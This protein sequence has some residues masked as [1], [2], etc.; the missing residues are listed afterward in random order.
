MNKLILACLFGL[1]LVS[2]NAQDKELN[3]KIN[4]LKKEGKLNGDEAYF[5][6]LGGTQGLQL[7]TPTASS[8][9]GSHNNGTMTS[10]ACNCWIPRDTS[11]HVVPF[12]GSGGSGGPGV[13]PTYANDDWSTNGITLPFNFCLYGAN[14]GSGTKKLFINNNGNVSFGSAYSTFSAVAFPSTQYIMV[15]PFWGDVETTNAGSGFVYYKL[16]PT[17]LIV[18]WDS[19]TYYQSSSG[20]SQ[21]KNTFQLIITDG[22]DP[23]LSSGNNVS[24]CYGD[25]QWTTGDASGGTN[26]FGGTPATVGINKGS[27]GNYVQISLFGANNGNFTNPAG[28]PVSGVN[29]LDNKSFYFNSCGSSTNLPPLATSGASSCAGDTINICAVG[30]TVIQSVSFTGPEPSQIVTVTASAPGIGSGFSILNSTAGT[31]GSLTFQVATGSLTTGYYNVS[32]TGTDNGI[33]VQSTTL[34]YVIHILG[35]AVPSP[36]ITVNP[37]ITCGNTPAIFTLTN[38]SSYDSYT[39]SNGAT[40]FS[41]SVSIT[42]T[43]QVTVVKNGCS[44][45]GTA[46]AY[47][48]PKPLATIGGALS[49]CSPAT[50]TNIY[51]NQP[52]TGGTAPFTYN[53]D[54][55]ASSS[56]SLTASAGTH[57]VSVTDAHGC[58]DTVF[59]TV[60]GNQVPPLTIIAKGSLCAGNDTLI[61]S[62]TNA[63]SYVWTPAGSTTYT[64]VVNSPGIYSLNVI[65]N[66]CPTSATYSLSP[67]I[68]PTLTVTGEF[69][70][71][72][73]TSTT[74]TVTAVPTGTYNYIW[75]GGSNVTGNTDTINMANTYTV[76]GVNNNTQCVG[77]KVFTVGSYTNPI[78]SISGSTTY[79]KSKSD[80][81][82]ANASGGHGPYTYSWSPSATV[83]QVQDS[84]GIVTPPSNVTNITY[85]VMIID[86]KGCVASAQ[87]PLKQSNPHLFVANSGACAGKTIVLNANGSGTAPLTYTWTNPSGVLPTIVIGKKDSAKAPG[88]YTVTMTD[89][90]GCTA[91]DSTITISQY[92]TPNANFTYAPTAVEAGVPATF[93]DASTVTTG[94]ITSDLWTF[95]DMDSA[96]VSNPIHTYN[97]GGTYT[98]TLTVKSD[99]GCTNMITKFIDIQYVVIAPNIITPNGDG[100]NEFLAFKNLQYFKNN[101]L[102]IYNRWGVQLYTDNDY[103]NNWT[104]KDFSDGTYFYI[105]DLP[106]KHT[107]LKGFFESI[108]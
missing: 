11:F 92:P 93:T 3:E 12:D 90:Y 87:V 66:N 51:V 68:T 84:I 74:L 21:L 64:N 81:L 100:I 10:T 9:R 77:T 72:S 79:C 57:T 36:S 47:I 101:K 83:M 56:T 54:N 48:Y 106:D 37:G 17:Y 40:T 78:V 67:P 88:T 23:I 104:G 63:T 14:L 25:M 107:T 98:V 34:N 28:S 59:A 85:S 91:K 99:K 24:F 30:D 44:K 7:T 18:Q 29:W 82:F 16:T 20:T 39:W 8:K 1:T 19:V 55:G 80:S 95:G 42:S 2:L 5:N 13:A 38:A 26:G 65:I 86:S 69:F 105:L 102:V 52:V 94:S 62:I 45:S 71:C 41:T 50:S 61:A 4:Q 58:S 103:K 22:S 76:T 97:N 43:L 33:P 27:G 32:V 60:V 49:Y 53:W 31:T 6:P 89:K 108:K 96:F 35:T 46:V 70:I 75:S 15:A 73:G